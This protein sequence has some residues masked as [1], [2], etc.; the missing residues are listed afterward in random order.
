MS[1]PST[2]DSP[3]LPLWWI[4]AW[5]ALGVVLA[6]WLA[7]VPLQGIAHVQDEI[8]YE[9]QARVLGEGRLW[10]PA[11]LPRAAHVFPF[12][13]N[14]APSAAFPDGRRFGIFP[15][16]WPLVLAPG[17]LLGLPWLV[18]PLLHGALVAAGAALAGLLGGR[19]SAWLAAPLLALSPGL[20][21]Q[22]GSRMSHPLCAL[23]AVVATL[24]L[25]RG[26]SRARALGLGAAL[27]LLLLTRPLDA[28][29]VGAVLGLAA[30]VRGEARAWSPAVPV[31]G[32][33][34]GLV[35]AQNLLYTGDLG[36]FAQHAW[37]AAGEPPFPSDQARFEAGCNALGFGPEHGCSP[38][39]GSLGHTPAKALAGMA[40]NLSLAAT[41]WA[42]SPVLLLFA[43][44]APRRLL[45]L[46]LGVWLAVAA[47][48]GLYWYA[49]PC[50]GGRFHHAAAGLLVV[51]TAAG[52]ASAT[53]RMGLPAVA[54]LLALPVAGWRLSQALPELSGYWGVDGRLAELEAG[55]TD[56]PALVFVAY[57]PPWS[58][59]AE[60]PQTVGGPLTYSANQRRGMWIER[61][62]GPLV[63]AEL[64]P[65]LVEATAAGW[66]DRKRY[67]LVL[68]GSAETDL[69]Q[70][71]PPVTEAQV[72][73][74]AL[75]VEPTA[76][77]PGAP[78]QGAP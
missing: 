73:D 22:A 77:D 24:L 43:L 61:R 34:V 39:F 58:Q 60:L 50:L 38:T 13:T 54:G 8:V 74:L 62:E 30:L 37:F 19:R 59:R 1:G 17:V 66:P 53:R 11:R 12:V 31:V 7:L 76:I 41:L 67:L 6:S 5:V 32:A 33:A 28:V 55:W 20:L 52:I 14:E 49:G 70:P 16:G 23:L 68:T 2:T 63:Y 40:R 42:G 15:N 36:T 18:N 51:A 64:Q 26:P 65:A 75:P 25:V 71:L 27:G 78:R 29:A 44:A 47:A 56:D 69:L 4:L 10:E 3:A 9:L 72:D 48:Y 57:G 35:L 45:A 21:L 46:A